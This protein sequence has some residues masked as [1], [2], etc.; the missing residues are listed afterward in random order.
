MC[1]TKKSISKK[2]KFCNHILL[3]WWV[4]KDHKFKFIY[5]LSIYLWRFSYEIQILSAN[6]AW[7]CFYKNEF[8]F[9]INSHVFQSPTCSIIREQIIKRIY[10]WP[11]STLLGPIYF[12]V[13]SI[14]SSLTI[15]PINFLPNK[16]FNLSYS[17]PKA[18]DKY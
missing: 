18:F 5:H 6:V 13:K 16:S 15:F 17:N 14:P 3:F 12:E 2:S 1:K 8:G 10:K 4:N 9:F 11:H 7:W